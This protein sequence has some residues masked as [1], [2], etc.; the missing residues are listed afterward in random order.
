MTVKL[1]VIS[2]KLWRYFNR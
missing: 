2:F 1:C